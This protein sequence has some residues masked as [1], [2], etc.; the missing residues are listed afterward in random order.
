MANDQPIDDG[1]EPGENGAWVAGAIKPLKANISRACFELAME[2]PL[3][4]RHWPRLTRMGLGRKLEEHVYQ[5]LD[6]AVSI[7]NPIIPTASKVRHLEQM[8]TGSDAVLVYLRLGYKGQEI[9]GRLYQRLAKHTV[10][11]G[12]QVGGLRKYLATAAH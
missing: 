2:L 8:S 7:S 4:M 3:M 10:A 12:K 1:L 11:I 6:A 9:D 5:L